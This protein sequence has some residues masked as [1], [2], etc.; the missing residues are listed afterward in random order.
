MSGLIMGSI[1]GSPNSGNSMG[2]YFQYSV[3]PLQHNLDQRG[4]DQRMKENYYLV[5]DIV[6]GI[7]PYDDKKHKGRIQ[8]I[9][10][11]E[12]GNPSLIYVLTE[13]SELLP[14]KFESIKR[15]NKPKKVYRIN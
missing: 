14:L 4:G 3:L 11:N 1:G 8:R 5:G 15:I 9:V 10:K 2:P 7:S 6:E 12:D 13:E